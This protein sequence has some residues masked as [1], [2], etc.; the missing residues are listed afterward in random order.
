MPTTIS[1]SWQMTDRWNNLGAC[2]C[3]IA[4]PPPISDHHFFLSCEFFS[5]LQAGS[6]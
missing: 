5:L 6:G 4:P 2:I 1:D 3:A